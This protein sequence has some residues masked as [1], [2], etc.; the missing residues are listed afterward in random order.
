M[1]TRECRMCLTGDF[2]AKGPLPNLW[3]CHSC[4]NTYYDREVLVASNTGKNTRKIANSQERRVA[5]KVG[6]Q[7]T[8]ASGQTP[9]DKADVKSSVIR[10]ECKTTGAKSY[11][12]KRE[13]L[14]KIAAQA[15]GDKI[16]V[17]VVEFTPGRSNY[18]IVPEAWFLELLDAY[19]QL[20]SRS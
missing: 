10:A 7:Q 9:I 18:Y 19:D 5:K 17:F 20:H 8:L 11:T 6:G 2:L 14:E 15:E 4:G 1:A 12:L 16:P 13:D 3:T